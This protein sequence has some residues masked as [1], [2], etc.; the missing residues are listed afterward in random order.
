MDLSDERR[1]KALE[2]ENRRLKKLLAES[3]IDA[4]TLKKMLRKTSDAQIATAGCDLGH[5]GQEL[6]ATPCVCTG[7]PASQNLSLCFQA[8]GR[9][10]NPPE[11]AGTRPAAPSVRVSRLHLL[12]RREG[13]M[14]NHKKLYRLYRE[15]RLMDR[16]RGGRKRAIGTR[17]PMALSQGPNQ[18][19]SLDFVSDALACGRKFRVLAVTMTSLGN[20]WL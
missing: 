5:Q 13:V 14:L 10:T 15:E 20:A 4:A 9:R 8:I 6:L 7:W 18:R 16:K 2:D 11:A 19:W 3:M 17:A 1:L 12:L